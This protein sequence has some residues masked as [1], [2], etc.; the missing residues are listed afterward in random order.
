MFLAKKILTALFLPPAGLLLL[1]FLGLW[2]IARNRQRP[3]VFGIMLLSISLTTLLALSLPAVGKRLLTPLEY[4]P[5][6][7]A[8]QLAQAQAI[9]VLAGGLYYN[10]PEYRGDTVNYFSLERARYAAH[11]AKASGLPLLV[12]GG[13]PGGSTPE[14]LAIREVLEK[15]FG[16][17]VKW[18]ETA[19]RDTAEN[20]SFSAPLLKAAGIGRIAL[21]SHVWHLPRAIPLFEQQGLTV[22]PAPT[23]YSTPMAEPAMDWLPSDFRMSRIALHEHLGHL[24][25]RLR[26]VFN[27]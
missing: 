20:A 1:A 26:L 3:H 15:E 16:V 2:L 14:A 12:T 24:F 23:R 13:T 17:A 6:I 5:P 21:V 27:P 8:E 25:D 10:A 7:T 18:T 11:L 19:S 4:L 9:V 22:I